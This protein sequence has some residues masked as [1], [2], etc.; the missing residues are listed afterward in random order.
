MGTG[1]LQKKT[2]TDWQHASYFSALFSTFR[3]LCHYRNFTILTGISV[4]FGFFPEIS[5]GF[6]PDFFSGGFWD[7]KKNPEFRKNPEKWHDLEMFGLQFIA[8]SAGK[9]R[10]QNTLFPRVLADCEPTHTQNYIFLEGMTS[11]N[12][13]A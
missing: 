9:L 11:L 3:N 8:R 4:F 10:S 7:F 2:K 5:T 6:S 13:T 12:S 1:K